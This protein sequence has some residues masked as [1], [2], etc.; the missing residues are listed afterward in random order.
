MVERPQ[1]RVVPAVNAL[2]SQAQWL[3]AQQMALACQVGE[4]APLHPRM[5]S[6]LKGLVTTM[7]ELRAEERLEKALLDVEGLS[8]EE[9]IAELERTLRTLR[10]TT[11]PPKSQKAAICE[12]SVRT[13]PSKQ[14]R[15]P[16]R[17]A[18]QHSPGDGRR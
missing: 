4:S 1:V 17:V 11:L 2:A 15:K 18:R 12:P 3:L 16:A 13:E 8:R 6:A 7:R 14:K 10:D 5:A 9:L